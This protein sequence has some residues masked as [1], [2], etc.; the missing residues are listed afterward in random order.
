MFLN[1]IALITK[2][3]E[4]HFVERITIIQTS[5]AYLFKLVVKQNDSL[6]LVLFRINCKVLLVCGHRYI[7]GLLYDIS[8]PPYKDD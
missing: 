6:S 1:Y 2:G 8:Q 4:I 5:L 3:T 7:C